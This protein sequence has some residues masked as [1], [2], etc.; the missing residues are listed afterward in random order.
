MFNNIIYLIFLLFLNPVLLASSCKEG[1]NN[2]IRCD[3]ITKLCTKCT[4]DIY[5]PDE[6]G[7]CSA[8]R[9]CYLG[10]N[11]CSECD[12]EEKKCEKCEIG[13]YP[14]Q[15]GG[16]SFV[17]NCEI[18]NK[19][20]CLKCISDFILVGGE[21]DMF[22]ICKSLESEDLSNCKKINQ[23]T[24]F[25]EECEAGFFLNQGDLK[26]SKIENCYESVFGKCSLCNGGFY[27]DKKENKCKSQSGSFSS[28]K[29]SLDGEKCDICD[30]DFFFDEKG[31]CIGVNFCMEGQYYGCKRCVEDY[32]LAHDKLSCTKEKHCYSGDRLNG[33]CNFCFGDY[34]IDL[35]TRKC[36]SNQKDNDFKYC[37]KVQNGKCIS[38]DYEYNLSE[39]GKCSMTTNCAEVENGICEECSDKYYLT[40][41]N[42]CL[43]TE[44]CIYSENYYECKECEDGYF[45]NKTGK[46]CSKFKKNFENCKSTSYDGQYCFW[47]K[48]GFYNNQ[49]DH[50]CYENKEKNNFYKCSLSDITGKYCIG[51]EDEYFI[52]NKDHKCSK[53]DGCDVSENAEKC[54]ECDERFCLNLK[55]GVCKYN[56]KVL[57]ED[58]KFYFRCNKTNKE[59]NKCEI[60]IDEYELSEDGLCMDKIHCTKEEDG[61]CIKCKNNREYS[62]CLNDDFGCVPT[63]YMKCIECNN[64][65][66]FNIC[67]KC[68][69]YYELNEYGVCIDIDEIYDDE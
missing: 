30:D 32:F 19:G 50:L 39:D 27:L 49:T 59:G 41:D 47:C 24:G 51:C 13:F 12:E 55:T 38:C 23:M 66:D 29:V 48:N 14:D 45:Y 2:C 54:V 6:D 42:R 15:N 56:E 21:N 68:P 5:S 46:I 52:G 40:L 69:K 67:T 25:C 61:V 44:R 8:S 1:S 37:K 17:D 18:S 10:K 43:T 63:S 31:V 16:C 20:F 35:D 28:C 22:K 64:N 62:S 36:N 9:K 3:P 33:L 7:G 34:Y 26:C 60:C 57:S 4:L 58:E 11:Y 53:I 65:L